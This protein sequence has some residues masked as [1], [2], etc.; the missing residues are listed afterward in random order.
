MNLTQAEEYDLKKQSHLYDPENKYV[1]DGQIL[2][3]EEEMGY[4]DGVD[5]NGDSLG[6]ITDTDHDGSYSYGRDIDVRAEEQ[7]TLLRDQIYGIDTA[8]Y[9]RRFQEEA[10]ADDTSPE[11]LNTGLKDDAEIEDIVDNSDDIDSWFADE[12][13]DDTWS[14][15]PEFKNRVYD[16][17]EKSESH[18]GPEEDFEEEL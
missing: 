15:N 18:D 4:D 3:A 7:S 9:A 8:E 17:S 2:G 12:Q 6:Y 5:Y 16:L 1:G 11:Y 13:D 14:E 10:T